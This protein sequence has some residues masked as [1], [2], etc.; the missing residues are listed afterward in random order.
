MSPRA[1]QGEEEGGSAPDT[2]VLTTF[3][4]S[5]ASA[6]Q[7]PHPPAAPSPAAPADALAAQPGLILS[8][9][10]TVVQLRRNAGAGSGGKQGR[11]APA[12]PRRTR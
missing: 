4:G 7:P 9:K 11:Q 12:P 6:H 3:G 8:T 2:P 10:S 1:P 5:R